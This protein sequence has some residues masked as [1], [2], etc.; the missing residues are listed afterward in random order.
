MTPWKPGDGVLLTGPAPAEGREAADRDIDTDVVI[1]GA[2]PGGAACARALARA[3]VRVVILEEGPPRSRFA[4][5]QGDTMRYHMQ[6]GGAM[7]ATGSAYMPIAAGRGL[8]G[9]TL[10]NSAIAWRAPDHVLDG[11]AETLGDDRYG[12]AALRP[13]YDELWDELSAPPKY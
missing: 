13:I 1:V 6:E 8:G 2:G 11:W 12:A 4:A 9:G 3:G 10:I 7:V 5:N